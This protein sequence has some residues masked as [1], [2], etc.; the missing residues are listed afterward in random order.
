M[1]GH[2]KW[3]RHNRAGKE[4]SELQAQGG[5]SALRNACRSRTTRVESPLALAVRT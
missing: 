4:R 3:S 1:P 2:E 5:W